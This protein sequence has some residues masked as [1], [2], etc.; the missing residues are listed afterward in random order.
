MKGQLPDR[1]TTSGWVVFAA[2]IIFIS[3][4][5]NLLWAVTLLFQDDWIVISS[6]AII[7]FN[8]TTAGVIFL[9]FALFQGC[10]AAATL[11]GQLWARVLGILG[12]SFN[13]FTHMAFMSLYPAWAWLGVLVNGLIIYGLTVHGDEVAER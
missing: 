12:A 11:T 6:Q 7:R 13:L 4:S 3:S 8:T 5:V 2:V 9:L 1:Q 10:V